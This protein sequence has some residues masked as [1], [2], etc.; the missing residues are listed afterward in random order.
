MFNVGPKW[1]FSFAK[2]VREKLHFC[3]FPGN[4]R[5]SESAKKLQKLFGSAFSRLIICCFSWSWSR[6]LLR[7][8]PRCW[9]GLLVVHI[10]WCTLGAL[11]TSKNKK[12]VLRTFP[13]VRNFPWK[14]AAI[15][16]EHSFGAFIEKVSPF[17]PSRSLFVLDAV[18]CCDS[19]SVPDQNYSQKNSKEGRG[20]LGGEH[21][22]EFPKAGPILQQEF[23]FPHSACAARNSGNNFPAASEFANKKP[24]SKEF[25]TATAL[26]SFLKIWN[27]YFEKFTNIPGSKLRRKGLGE[28]L[29]AKT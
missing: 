29:F 20:G 3:T 23:S 25:R 16:L 12:I 19:G 8:P 4:C 21:P 7:R 9:N 1:V 13:L 28:L 14:M 6:W 11:L 22:A 17:M 24:S 5:I 10:C 18:L 26:S 15:F 27:S 2:T